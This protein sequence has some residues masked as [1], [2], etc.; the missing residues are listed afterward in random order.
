MTGQS[1]ATL[2]QLKT[3]GRQLRLAAEQR[4]GENL[5]GLVDK[6]LEVSASVLNSPSDNGNQSEAQQ[7]KALAIE[8]LQLQSEIEHLASPWMDDLRILLREN[9]QGQA[10]S[11]TYRSEP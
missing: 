9:R 7:W 2:E 6:Y 5:P 1:L 4:D 10:L 3:L 8:V 11:N